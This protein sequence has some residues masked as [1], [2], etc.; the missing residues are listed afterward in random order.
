MKHQYQAV[1]KTNQDDSGASPCICIWGQR[2]SPSTPNIRTGARY[3]TDAQKDAIVRL[4]NRSK[5]VEGL[6]AR[7]NLLG[8]HLKGDLH[9]PFSV[10]EILFD[11]VTEI[12]EDVRQLATQSSVIRTLSSTPVYMCRHA[13]AIDD[14]YRNAFL[15]R[16]S[17]R[18]DAKRS[19]LIFWRPSL[20]R[21]TTTFF[22]LSLPHVS[23]RS[24]LQK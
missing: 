12:T 8:F 17:G 11:G 14:V 13:L 10:P 20:A 18:D 6:A 4:K 23:L 21:K 16:A 7:N 1:Q 22:R 3:G 19:K 2:F 5:W 24:R 9:T 15:I